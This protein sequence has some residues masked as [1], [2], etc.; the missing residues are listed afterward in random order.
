MLKF[1]SI[2]INKV[3]W[4]KYAKH[5][6]VGGII[7]TNIFVFKKKIIPR[8]IQEQHYFCYLFGL[9]IIYETH[10]KKVKIYLCNIVTFI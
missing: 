3:Q 7:S 10:N 4:L 9:L 6:F 8:V 2:S 5:H 1:C